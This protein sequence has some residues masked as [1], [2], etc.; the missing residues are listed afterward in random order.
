[1]KI[2]KGLGI[3]DFYSK[4]SLISALNDT[5]NITSK[6]LKGFAS[7]DIAGRDKLVMMARRIRNKDIE[8]TFP[9]ELIELE[10]NLNVE[11]R[12]DR[13][14]MREFIYI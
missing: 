11:A 8:S 13:K 4:D 12:E 7:D 9:L 14:K 5:I 2:E 10:N 3:R 1:M 6:S